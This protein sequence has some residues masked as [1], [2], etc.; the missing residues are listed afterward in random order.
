MLL[1]NIYATAGRWDDAAKVRNMMREHGVKKE[2]GLSWIEV[3][4]K[5]H[6]FVSD[7]N[8]HPQVK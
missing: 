3:K 7:D 5:V 8:L 1:S 4:S 6:T 2:V